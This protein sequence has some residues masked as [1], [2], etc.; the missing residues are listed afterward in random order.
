MHACTRARMSGTLHTHC[1]S[2]FQIC[3]ANRLTRRTTLQVLTSDEALEVTS[4][5]HTI[6]LRRVTASSHTFVEWVSDFSADA[7]TSVVEDR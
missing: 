7:S 2:D 6:R 5:I 1:A 4:A 3:G